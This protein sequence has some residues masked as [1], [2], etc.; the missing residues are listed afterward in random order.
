MSRVHHCK[1]CACIRGEQRS[2][3]VPGDSES[4]SFTFKSNKMNSTRLTRAKARGRVPHPRG[5]VSDIPFLALI[6]GLPA[7]LS[8]GLAADFAG[9]TFTPMFSVRALELAVVSH[10]QIV[11][12]RPV[13]D[14]AQQARLRNLDVLSFLRARVV[15]LLQC[16]RRFL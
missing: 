16:P 7:G 4:V 2:E 6:A 13:L 12:D 3:G 15:S 8:A 5:V 10:A 1:V 14:V 9:A 11:L